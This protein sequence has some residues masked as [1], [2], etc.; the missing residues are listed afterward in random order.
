MEIILAIPLIAFAL[1]AIV[2]FL[3]L[4]LTKNVGV[5]LSLAWSTVVGL[6]VL[7]AIHVYLVEFE[8]LISNAVIYL[9]ISYCFFH[10]VHIPVASVRIR[11]LLEL[12]GRPTVSEAELLKT[13]GASQILEFRVKRLTDS[14][15]IG[16]V[17]GIL[18]TKS[19]KIYYVAALLA[20]LK[21]F[22]RR[23]ESHS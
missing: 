6:V 4:R 21:R 1:N 2:N 15:Q 11:V 22:V 7:L 14:N 9:A 10:F 16:D 19:K 23:G 20:Q 17:G 12:A 5:V 13:Y 3:I 18:T 8:F